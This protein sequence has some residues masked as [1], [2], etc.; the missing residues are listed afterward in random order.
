MPLKVL[1]PLNVSVPA[2]SLVRV[3]PP[4]RMPGIETSKPL[5][6]I[7]PDPLLMTT[8]RLGSSEKPAPARSVPPNKVSG[9]LVAPR[10]LSALIF[11]VAGGDE[12]AAG[13][14]V[15]RVGEFLRAGADLYDAA[16]AGDSAVERLARVVVAQHQAAGCQEHVAGALQRPGRLARRDLDQRIAGA[17]IGQRRA[18][19]S[20][21]DLSPRK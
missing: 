8:A 18:V 20:A 11:N 6:S 15:A 4:E 13:V 19:R 5:V 14:T 12:G 17:D 10:S 7:V 2:L 16:S 3:P 1:A 9:P 21:A